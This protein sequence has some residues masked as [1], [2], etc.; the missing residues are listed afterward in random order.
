MELR[1][2]NL[3]QMFHRES[4]KTIYF[5]GQKVKGDGHAYK[6]CRRGCLHSC[7]C[8]RFVVVV[9]MPSE[10]RQRAVESPRGTDGQTDRRT[11]R[12]AVLTDRCQLQCQCVT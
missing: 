12:N 8:W 5:W 4:G 3:T 2:P 11:S 9:V 6:Q 7:E 1:S 10:S